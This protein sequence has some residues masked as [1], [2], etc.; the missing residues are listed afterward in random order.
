VQFWSQ[1]VPFGQ[2]QYRPFLWAARIIRWGAFALGV[3]SSSVAVAQE[4]DFLETLLKDTSNVMIVLDG[5]GSMNQDWRDGATK[6]EVARDAMTA[7]TA[8][9]PTATRSGAVTFGPRR[10]FD[11]SDIEVLSN[12]TAAPASLA[13]ALAA[14]SPQERGMRPLADAIETAAARLSQQAG[15]GAI[16]VLTDG[17]EECGGNSCALS[18]PLAQMQIPV[19]LIGLGM[20]AAD[21]ALLRCLPSSAGGSFVVAEPGEDLT[22]LIAKAL[23]LSH[24]ANAQRSAASIAR[25]LLQEQDISVRDLT[26]IRSDLT[27]LDD[28]V[29]ALEGARGR[30][31]EP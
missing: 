28:A 22:P 5:S 13:Q 25:L 10:N 17:A 12:P 16:V 7:T 4:S 26:R 11:C 20:D 19:H 6:F 24:T 14:E 15:P 8:N 31:F 23:S 18:A 2:D 9:L 29:S 30:L 3:L 27:R 1:T 21:A